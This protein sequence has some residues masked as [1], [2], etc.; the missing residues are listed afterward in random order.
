MPGGTRSRQPEPLR[1]CRRLGCAAGGL[2]A[3]GAPGF[4]LI[5]LLV[6]VAIIAILA[7][8][9]LPAL[10]SAKAK[11]DKALCQSNMRQW[12]VAVQ[13]YAGD[14]Q[15]S[16]PDNTKGFDLSWCSTNVQQFWR[17]YLMPQ[18]KTKTE[19]DKFHVVFCP[20]QVWHRYADLWRNNDPNADNEPVLTGYF[21]LPYRD[22]SLSAWPY[23]SC[24]LKDWHFR[25][26]L[27]GT[28]ANAPILIDMLQGQGMASN[29]GNT[30][31][32]QTW[33]TTDNGKNIPTASHRGDKG[34]PTGGNFLFEDGHVTW[35]QRQQIALGSYASPWLCFYKIPIAT[36]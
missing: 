26:K 20:T 2:E 27:G 1:L 9:L 15:D 24:G 21:Y 3:S 12:G 10:S 17:Q 4:T 11:A 7:S 19:K 28:L 22:N 8:L 32:V 6:V 16:F 23:N 36:P 34:E 18:L 30:V 25:K 14:S 29:N 33:F 5:E 35:Y 13:M 31:S